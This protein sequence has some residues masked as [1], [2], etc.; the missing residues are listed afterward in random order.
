MGRPGSFPPHPQPLG[1]LR[2]RLI[3]ALERPVDVQAICQGHRPPVGAF[4]HH[5][6]DFTNGLRLIVSRDRQGPPSRK[7]PSPRG[8]AELRPPG[9]AW[10]TH[11]APRPEAASA[12]DGGPPLQAKHDSAGQLPE[13][14]VHVSAPGADEHGAPEGNPSQR[15]P[16]DPY[17]VALRHFWA[18]LGAEIPPDAYRAAADE[19]PHLY[20]PAPQVLALLKGD[21]PA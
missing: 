16:I 4:P 17:Y 20:F 10:D 2:C 8:E 14:S 11:K 19:T 15:S 1:L 9:A 6:F 3:G 12:G 13:E 18:L 7:G 5:V 21:E